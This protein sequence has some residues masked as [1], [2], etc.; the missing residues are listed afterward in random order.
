MSTNSSSIAESR[1]HAFGIF[2]AGPAPG[3]VAPARRARARRIL[4]GGSDPHRARNARRPLL[5]LRGHRA[6]RRARS[7]DHGAAGAGP[8]RHRRDHQPAQRGHAVHPLRAGRLHHPAG[9]SGALR[10][11][12]VADRQHRRP[13]QRRLHQPAKAAR[14]PPA[15]SSMRPIAGCSTATCIWRSSRSCR[16][17]VDQVEARVVLGADTPERSCT[18]RSRIWKTC[19]RSAWSIRFGSKRSCSTASRRR[20]A[21]AGRSAARWP[22]PR[23]EGDMCRDR[24]NRTVW[25]P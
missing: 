13:P 17:G 20:S 25:R 16:R 6:S 14:S 2:L 3:M 4:L 21:S 15:A 11:Q 22:E 1:G 24:F 10:D 5:R 19:F 23:A 18:A 8:V 9:Q 7:R 12:L